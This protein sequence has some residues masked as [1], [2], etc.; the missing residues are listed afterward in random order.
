MLVRL[1]H[2]GQRGD[3]ILFLHYAVNCTVEFLSVCTLCVACRPSP[4]SSFFI[5]WF[6]LTM[7]HGSGREGLVLSCIVVNAYQRTKTGQALQWQYQYTTILKLTIIIIAW[8]SQV[9]MIFTTS[10]NKFISISFFLFTFPPN[11][12]KFTGNLW[13]SLHNNCQILAFPCCFSSS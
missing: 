2:A 6:A 11:I 7:T 3:W 5:H 10:M 12:L 8:N 1:L 9:C 4:F 13:Y